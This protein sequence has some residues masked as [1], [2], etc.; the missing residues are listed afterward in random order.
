MISSV[1]LCGAF[2]DWHVKKNS[3]SGSTKPEHRLPP[4]VLGNILVPLGLIAFGWTAERLVHW[5]VP[6]LFTTL[7][8]FG[9]VAVSLASWS[10]LVDAFG[11]YAASAIAATT[12]LR[13]IAAAALPLAAPPLYS[14][15]GLGWGNTILGA[16][17]LAVAPVPMLLIICGEKMRN[18]QRFKVRLDGCD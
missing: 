4:M 3:S 13:N 9:F 16:L 5:I 2:L 1:I 15:L 10:Y 14:K 17:A 8:G 12:V 18:G 7:V 6:I 11:V